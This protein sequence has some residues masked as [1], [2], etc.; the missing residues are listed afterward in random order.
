MTTIVLVPSAIAQDS[1]GAPVEYAHAVGSGA[2]AGYLEPI[3]AYHRRR[4]REAA[5]YIDLDKLELQAVEAPPARPFR[6]ALTAPGISVIAEMK[7]RSPS[8]G[9]LAPGLEPRQVA[10]SYEAGGAACLSV[11]TDEKYFGGSLH[12]LGEARAACRLP[13]LRKDFTVCDADVLTAR[14][15]GADAVLLIV[16]ALSPIELRSF[17]ELAERLGMACIVEVHDAGEVEIAL[18]SGAGVIGVNQRDLHSF[19]VDRRLAERLADTMPAGV[20]RVAE[21]GIKTRSEVERLENAGYDAVL[22]GESLV[23]A[24]DPV[25][26]LLRLR[27][28]PSGPA[29]TPTT[30][31]DEVWGDR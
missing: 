18:G 13:V 15:A 21:S 27:G 8:K 19:D 20:V 2:M 31:S 7:R 23:T 14:R 28:A 16:A 17:R 5:R 10:R 24:G 4:A 11:L 30:G 3:V 12:D 25:A 29:T 9:L 1:H 26:E 6:A 22:I